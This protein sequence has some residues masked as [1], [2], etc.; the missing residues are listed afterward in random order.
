MKIAQDTAAA[1]DFVEAWV[2]LL[3]ESRYEDAF[4]ML[5]VPSDNSWSPSL[6][7]E[8][9]TSYELPPA[10]GDDSDTSHVTP[11]A[12]A[13]VVD[14]RPDKEVEWYE[15]N[16]DSN[17][18]M[19]HY[20]LPINGIWSDLTAIFRLLRSKGEVGVALEDIHVM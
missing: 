3:S 7:E 6:I 14:Y 8:I 18:G 20:S 4:N 16:P 5:Y 17:L 2:N 19:I 10:A 1:L 13:K 9:T 11:V 15:G 12:T